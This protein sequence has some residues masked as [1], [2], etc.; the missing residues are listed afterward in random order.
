MRTKWH[1]PLTAEGD[2]LPFLGRAGGWVG[3]AAEGR[4]AGQ[5]GAWPDAKERPP[6][7]ADA[8][9]EEPG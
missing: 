2:S 1:A 5:A 8:A 6:Q 3:A 9:P 7:R 4:R